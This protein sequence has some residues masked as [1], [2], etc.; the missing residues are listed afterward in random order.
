MIQLTLAMT[1]G[2]PYSRFIAHTSF[3]MK[4]IVYMYNKL[5]VVFLVVVSG[6]CMTDCPQGRKVDYS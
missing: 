4:Q 6:K 1:T 5:I 2:V 3:S